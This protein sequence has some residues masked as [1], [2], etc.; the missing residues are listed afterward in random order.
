LHLLGF[1]VICVGLVA[2]DAIAKTEVGTTFIGS[3]DEVDIAFVAGSVDV[4]L[5]GAEPVAD[6]AVLLCPEAASVNA[7]TEARIRRTAEALVN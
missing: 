6:R 7:T 4:T 2:W 3:D 5:L 1:T